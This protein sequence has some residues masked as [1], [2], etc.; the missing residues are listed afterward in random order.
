MS[1]IVNFKNSVSIYQTVF[2][3]VYTKIGYDH[4]LPKSAFEIIPQLFF[5]TKAVR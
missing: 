1:E 2:A 5:A 3:K 4:F